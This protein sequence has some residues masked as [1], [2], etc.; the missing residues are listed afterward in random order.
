MSGGGLEESPGAPAIRGFTVLDVLHAGGPATVYVARQEDLGRLVALKVIRGDVNEP[1][2]WRSFDREVKAVAR[3]SGHP[4]VV[5]VYTYG[6]TE[7][8]EAFLVT[9]YA[10]RGSLA[11]VIAARGALPVSEAA[12]VGVGMV[13]GLAAVHAIGLVHGNVNPAN[14]LLTSTGGAKLADFGMARF[15]SGVSA[16]AAPAASTDVYGLASTMVEALTGRPPSRHLT[17]VPVPLPPTVPARLAR[18]LTAALATDPQ[19]RPPLPE[20]RVALTDAA[21][22]AN[23][24]VPTAPAPILPAPAAGPVLGKGIHPRS[25]LR[26][27]APVLEAMALLV[28]VVAVVVALTR[29]DESAPRS[30]ATTVSPET[31][32]ST[33]ATAPTATTAVPTSATPTAS[34]AVPSTARTSPPATTAATTAPPTATASTVDRATLAEGFLRNYYA[35]VTAR[36]YQQAWALL[37]PEFQASTGGYRSYTT[38]WDTVDAAEVRRVQVQPAPN[39]GTWP[40]VAV[41]SMRYTVDGR[42]VDENDELTVQRDATGAPRIAAY[43]VVGGA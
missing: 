35:T 13:D 6:R 27:L 14:V 30:A 16:T 32:P 15:L 43:R 28:V 3:L 10:D 1:S 11:D 39:G 36:Q 34:T 25:R 37:T 38:F 26:R 12:A 42:V 22:A 20:L 19:A 40:I 33:V 31:A 4:H 7:A 9:E 2:R 17:T 29:P 21:R 24:A 23:D 5:A 8:A 18:V 41:L